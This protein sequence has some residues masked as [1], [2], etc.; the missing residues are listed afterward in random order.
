MEKMQRN[1]GIT[2]ISL[3]VTIIILIILA[4]I[5]INII[6]GKNGVIEKTKEAKIGTDIG[7]EKEIIQLAVGD[8]A[9]GNE[10]KLNFNKA[11][12]EKALKDNS[13]IENVK[14]E[15]DSGQ[16][17]KVT[18]LDSG[19]QYKV[20][21]DG[22]VR[23]KTEATS[24][25]VT[26]DGDVAILSNNP[27]NDTST[28]IKENEYR[29]SWGSKVKIINQ[30][31]PTY[32]GYWF[33]NATEIEGL[34]NLDVS[35]VTNMEG[36]FSYCKL[37]NIDILDWD[38]S[39]VTDMHSMFEGSDLTAVDV[40]AWD[41]SNVTDMRYMFSSCFKLTT[42]GNLDNWNVSNVTNMYSMFLGCD[43]TTVG[44]LDNWNVSNVT[45]MTNL[46]YNC[47]KLTIV[48]K[49]DNWNVSNVTTMYGMFYECNKLTTVGNLDKWD[50]SKVTSLYKMFKYDKELV[51]IG[52]ISNWNVSNV[53]DMTD[54]FGYCSSLKTVGNLN[55]W[56]VSKVQYMR[57]M[58][59][60]TT[61]SPVPSWYME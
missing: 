23:E 20:L 44:N 16:S 21:S 29:K 4:G 46:F 6:L 26:M 2:L 19:R 48:G 49:L 42:V 58:F 25:Y 17:Y 40:S 53:T 37:N 10:G 31:S 34:E 52:D 12:L 35:N 14:V 18:Y 9:T 41:V 13:N 56:D 28:D 55:K 51:T 57:D 38:V 7:R 22:R 1:K 30:I 45:D 24:V 54:M 33:C 8:I 59:Y 60:Q 36:M 47:H 43:F 61:L 11:S 39:N 15:K 5:T 27:I 32:T 3:V 50:V